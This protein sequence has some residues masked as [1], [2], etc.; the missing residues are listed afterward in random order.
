MSLS[1]CN[2]MN[3]LSMYALMGAYTQEG[4]QW[5]KEL[6]QVLRENTRFAC[7]YIKA[8]FTGVSVSQ[9]EGTYMLFLDCTGWCEKNGKTVDDILKACYDVGVALLDGRRFHGPCH[10][11][12]NV[13]LPMSRLQEA[14][15]RMHQYVFCA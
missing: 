7:D 3:L 6:R 13:A 10:L 1:Q 14:F 12:L 8:N 9:P 15:R 5:L 4:Q 2:S 11:R